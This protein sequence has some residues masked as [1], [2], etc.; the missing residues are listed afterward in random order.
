MQPSGLFEVLAE[1]ET[2]PPRSALEEEYGAALRLDSD[3][4]S[5]NFVSTIDGIVSFGKDT[6]DSR[7]VGGGV[8]ADRTLM[9]M[10]RAVAGVIVVG[11]GTLRATGNHQWTPRALAPERAADM[12]ALR[13]AAGLP[14]EPA[15]LLVVGG[16]HALPPH[17]DAVARPA[18]PLHVLTTDGVLPAAEALA[19]TGTPTGAAP[20]SAAAVIEAARQLS[21]GG[22]VLCEGGPHLFG[23]LLDGRVPIDLFLTVAPQLAGRSNHSA[24]RRSLVEGVALPPFTRRGMLR[25]VRRAD[26]H[27]LL[28]YRIDA[29]G[30][31]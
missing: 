22:P 27:L 4:V 11:A 29:A 8:A 15:P 24:E 20:V 30:N 23:T 28:R 13:M 31:A 21:G 17:A 18:V 5:V 9:A 12:D 2:S 16:S 3:R 25:S 14:S 19:R 6:D 26:N 1:T 7:A 10:L